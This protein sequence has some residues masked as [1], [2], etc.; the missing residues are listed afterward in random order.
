MIVFLELT[1][2]VFGIIIISK[3]NTRGKRKIIGSQIKIEKV[4]K[5]IKENI[6]KT[7]FLGINR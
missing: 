6:L 2:M 7:L 4:V 5:T 3:I 1:V